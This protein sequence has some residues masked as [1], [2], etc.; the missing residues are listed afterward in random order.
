MAGNDMSAAHRAWND[1]FNILTPEQVQNFLQQVNT[2]NS[3]TINNSNGGNTVTAP[4]V[5]NYVQVATSSNPAVP[6][7]PMSSA[8]TTRPAT[9]RGKR[10]RETGKLRP[11]NSFIAF[12]SKS[13]A[14]NSIEN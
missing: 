14:V 2:A 13:R 10:G 4:N 5:N 9:F 8:S 7:V 6:A 11:L 1:L 12:R 3:I